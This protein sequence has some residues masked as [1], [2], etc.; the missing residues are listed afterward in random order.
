MNP[1]YAPVAGVVAYR[2]VAGDFANESVVKTSGILGKIDGF[3][4]PFDTLDS[5]DTRFAQGCFIKSLAAWKRRERTL[6]MYVNHADNRPVGG[7]QE[8]TEDDTGLRARGEIVATEREWVGG[9]FRLKVVLGM[10]IGFVP[11]AWRVETDGTVTYTEVALREISL[12]TANS[13]P[14]AVIESLRGAGD[15]ALTIRQVEAALRAQGQSC[16]AAKAQAIRIFRDA[17]LRDE[18]AAPEAAGLRDGAG[19][20][21]LMKGLEQQLFLMRLSHVGRP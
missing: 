15:Q 6:P 8:V 16:N 2:F 13:V 12:V 10:S 19:E 3:A 14:G 4:C 1:K 21:A 7:W 17:G 18:A 20:A 5:H 11:V 9:L